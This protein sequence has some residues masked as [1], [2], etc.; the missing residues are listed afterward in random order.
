M[1]AGPGDTTIHLPPPHPGS[2]PAAAAPASAPAAPSAPQYGY[3]P[4]GMA[5]RAGDSVDVKPSDDDADS[6]QN[7]KAKALA[8]DGDVAEERR[9][10]GGAVVGMRTVMETL[11]RIHFNAHTIVDDDLRPMGISVSCG[12]QVK[13]LSLSLSVSVCVSV[14][15]SVCVYL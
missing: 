7:K 15:A 6:R 14:C 4:E 8:S 11:L 3:S 2:P 13:C 1:G 10:D 5:E 9:A 12:S